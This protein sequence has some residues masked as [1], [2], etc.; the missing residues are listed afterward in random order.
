MK[1]QIPFN[2]RITQISTKQNKE[3]EK[4]ERNREESCELVGWNSMAQ[5]PA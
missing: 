1:F 4:I 2:R 3:N 5:L